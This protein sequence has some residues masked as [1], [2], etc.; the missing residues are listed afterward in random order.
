MNRCRAPSSPLR[1]RERGEGARNYRAAD[2]AP[3][4]DSVS[5]KAAIR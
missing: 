3:T 2:A 1:E 5:M 4:F